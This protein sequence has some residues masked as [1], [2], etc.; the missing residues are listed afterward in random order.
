[1]RS[2]VQRCRQTAA[3]NAADF[4]FRQILLCKLTAIAGRRFEPENLYVV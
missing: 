4:P 2:C 3:Q 1:M